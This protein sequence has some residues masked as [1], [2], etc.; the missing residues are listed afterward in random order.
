MD[1]GIGGHEKYKNTLKKR[2]KL[3]LRTFP[4]TNFI[5]NSIRPVNFNFELL[6]FFIVF[7]LGITLATDREG[8]LRNIKCTGPSIAG[9]VHFQVRR[10]Q[11]GAD[12][13]V[14]PRR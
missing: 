3:G 12:G 7:S 14:W 2:M 4:L 10:H 8:I 6:K 9:P 1:M 11:S 5:L 13:V